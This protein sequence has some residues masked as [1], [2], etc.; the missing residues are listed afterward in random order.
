[1]ELNLERTDFENADWTAWG[2]E[3]GAAKVTHV[4]HELLWRHL[5]IYMHL[6]HDSHFRKTCVGGYSM[7]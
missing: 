1:M 5:H 7:I 6:L 2:S 3:R 4:T